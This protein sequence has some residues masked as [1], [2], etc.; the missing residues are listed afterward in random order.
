MRMLKRAI[1][2]GAAMICSLSAAHAGGDL[3]GSIKDDYAP[4][5]ASPTWYLRGDFSYAWQNSDTVSVYHPT[6]A[7]SSISDTWA[8][9]GGIGRYFGRG[10]RGD[11]TYEWRGNTDINAASTSCCSTTTHF[12]MRSQVLLANLYYDFRPGERF[13]PY[14]GAGIGTSRNETSGGFYT[15]NG[16]G[17]APY[18][19]KTQ[20][21]L[22][23]A[24]MAGASIRLD[25]GAQRVGGI[26]D[27][28]YVSVAEPGRMHLDLGYR[29]L[30]LGDAVS[31]PN[32]F[33]GIDGPKAGGIDAHE[34]RVGLRYD[35]R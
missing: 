25:R 4:V 21:N 2:A 14:I 8:L 16:C 9:G 26:K 35:L 22:A 27:D 34:L 29:Y 28:G 5:A 11:V 6:I 18:E 23:W 15:P 33:N 20:W 19:G 13:N 12:S 30:N 31:G 10:F 24:L 3:R 17:C 7:S 1:V 32:S